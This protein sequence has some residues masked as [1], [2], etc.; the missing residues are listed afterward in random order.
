MVYGFPTQIQALQFEWAWQ[1][2]EKSLD[3]REIAAR[4]GRTKRYGVAGKVG[5][6]AVLAWFCSCFWPLCCRILLL[7]NCAE[8]A[9]H[10][11]STVSA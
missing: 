1:H 6:A 9:V 5:A 7:S 2:P 10:G 8:A 3:V 11:L 4:L